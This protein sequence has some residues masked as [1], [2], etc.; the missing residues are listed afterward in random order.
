MRLNQ[1]Q[2][3]KSNSSY[4]NFSFTLHRYYSASSSF[5]VDIPIA[6]PNGFTI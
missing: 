1:F 3:N 5:K 6:N 2:L 4:A